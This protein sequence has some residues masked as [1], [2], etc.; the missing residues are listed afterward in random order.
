MFSVAII[1]GEDKGLTLRYPVTARF[2]VEKGTGLYLCTFRD[3]GF[4]PRAL[5]NVIVRVKATRGLCKGR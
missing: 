5:V 1:L 4:R 2:A 3:D